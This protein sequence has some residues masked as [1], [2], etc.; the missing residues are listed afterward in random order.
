M[1]TVFHTK[2][3]GTFIQ[4]QS[5]LGKKKLHRTNQVSNVLGGSFSNRDNV[6]A[7]F[8]F[9]REKHPGT[10]KNHFSARTDP[11]IFIQCYSTGKRNKLDFSSTEINKLLPSPVQC[12][13]DEIQVQQPT[14][15]VAT[16]QTPDHAQSREQY[17]QHTSQYY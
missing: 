6:R 4:L 5:N 13:V 10:L 7:P 2:L 14:L 8:Q 15:V 1:A 3:D 9:R 16:N 12:L 11:L 17:H